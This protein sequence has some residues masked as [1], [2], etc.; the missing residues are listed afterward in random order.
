MRPLQD[1]GSA[2]GRLRDEAPLP[3][4]GEG[5]AGKGPL[6][7]PFTADSL[8]VLIEDLKEKAARVRDLPPPSARHPERFHLERDEIA[9]ELAAWATHLE[10]RL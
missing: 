1:Q 4:A 9:R 2:R 3:R 10:R 5:G 8:K 6:T 7:Q